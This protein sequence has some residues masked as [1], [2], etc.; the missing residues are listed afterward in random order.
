[1]TPTTQQ[2]EQLFFSQ[3]KRATQAATNPVQIAR[4]RMQ[5]AKSAHERQ[6]ETAFLRSFDYQFS[7]RWVRS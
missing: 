7:D 4:M 6:S 3:M 5:A 2:V 1:M